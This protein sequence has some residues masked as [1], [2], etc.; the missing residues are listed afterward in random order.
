MELIQKYIFDK[1]IAL[2]IVHTRLEARTHRPAAELCKDD[3]QLRFI[4]I[5]LLFL[6][7]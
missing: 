2:K 3:A 1:N 4:I 5:H 7:Q 6:T